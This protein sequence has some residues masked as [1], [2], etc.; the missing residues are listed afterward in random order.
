MSSEG[1]FR[2]KVAIVTGGSSGIGQATCIALANMQFQIV[3]VG[4][5]HQGIDRTLNYL[6]QFPSNRPH[7]GLALNVAHEADMQIMVEKTLEQFGRIDLLI[8][9]AG[10]GKKSGSDR[11]IPPSSAV[12]PLDEWKEILNVNLTG[13]F[14]SNRAVLPT[15]ISQGSG[16]IINISSATSIHGLRGQP[17]APAYCASKFGVVGFS[18]SLAEEVSTYGIRVQV[19]LPGL[20]TTSLV[21]VNAFSRR[22]GG[23]SISVESLAEAIVGLVKQPIDAVTVDPCLLPFRDSKPMT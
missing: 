12:L 14:L 21:P 2:G 18:Q 13:V 8:A 11:I 7:Q 23:H 9:S 6:N 19:L 17:Y 20:V 1:L 10:L 5:N 4:T 16:Q 15:M 3:V 22:F